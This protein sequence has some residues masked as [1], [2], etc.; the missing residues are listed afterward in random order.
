MGRKHG[1]GKLKSG[2]LKVGG[3]WERVDKTVVFEAQ[4]KKGSIFRNGGQYTA[5]QMEGKR[6]SEN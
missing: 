3:K 6:A 2:H 1:T 5:T 4:S